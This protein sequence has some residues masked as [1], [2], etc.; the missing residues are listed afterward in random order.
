MKRR[1][2]SDLN[3]Q[4]HDLYESGVRPTHIATTLRMAAKTVNNRISVMRKAGRIKRKTAGRALGLPMTAEVDEN[5]M[6]YVQPDA[7]QSDEELASLGTRL[8]PADQSLRVRLL[9]E[10][11][12]YQVKLDAIDRLL[13]VL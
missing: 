5:H 2:I 7:T 13:Q 11:S 1:K 10:R 12:A 9:T 3:K 6:S 8:V 4:I